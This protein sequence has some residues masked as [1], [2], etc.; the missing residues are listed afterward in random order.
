MNHIRFYSIFIKETRRFLRVFGQTVVT[1]L[2]NASLFLLIFGMSLGN[3]LS[4]ESEVPYLT[5]LIPGL[6]MMGVLNNAFQN[7]SSSIMI[8]K[9]HGE[10]EDL[11]ITPLSSH[12]IVW[13]LSMGGL[14]RGMIVGLVTFITG[15]FFNYIAGNGHLHIQNPLLLILFLVIG[16]ISFA[17]IGLW[18]GFTATSF[19]HI[20]GFTSFVLLPLIYLGGVFFTLDNLHPVWKNITMVNPL[21]YYINGV[22]YSMIGIADVPVTSSL[23][24]S[25]L[26]LGASTALAYISVKRG[27]YNRF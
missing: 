17:Q 7:S 25:T 16:G 1:P 5:F 27:S 26:F 10:L 15:Y 3:K 14:F 18:I 4:V 23:T 9:F 24:V 19:D 20:S 6:I 12:H 13:G 11:K 22:R 8:S 21:L 2:I